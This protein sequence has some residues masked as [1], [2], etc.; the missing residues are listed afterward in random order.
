MKFGEKS[1]TI[2]DR[3]SYLVNLM[4]F[5][6]P[7]FCSAGIGKLICLVIEFLTS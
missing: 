3:C 7:T 4:I 2:K 6:P 1:N 5:S